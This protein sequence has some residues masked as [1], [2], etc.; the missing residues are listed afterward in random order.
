VARLHIAAWEE[1]G[2]G[3]PAELGGER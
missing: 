1:M 2:A 3:V